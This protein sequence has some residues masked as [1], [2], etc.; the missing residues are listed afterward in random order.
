VNPNNRYGLPAPGSPLLRRGVR[1]NGCIARSRR[2]DSLEADRTSIVD[3]TRCVARWRP[4][5]THH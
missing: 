4:G 2:R 1:S 3:G 5:E